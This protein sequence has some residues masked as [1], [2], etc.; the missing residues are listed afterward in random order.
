MTD[1]GRPLSYDQ[2]T[3]MLHWLEW[4]RDSEYTLDDVIGM[5]I[6]G[7]PT[8]NVTGTRANKSVSQ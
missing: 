8:T 4:L 3:D 6:D 5:I 2:W 1:V 7:P